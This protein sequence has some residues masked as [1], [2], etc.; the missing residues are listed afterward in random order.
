MPVATALEA[1]SATYVPPK[2]TTS[3]LTTPTK[4]GVPSNVADVVPSKSLLFAFNPEIVNAFVE[5]VLE[6]VATSTD[7]APVL[8]NTTLPL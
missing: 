8:D 2:V 5:T 3:L 6:A 7:V 4:E 1:K